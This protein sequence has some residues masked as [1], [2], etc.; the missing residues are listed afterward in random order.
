MGIFDR[1]KAQGRSGTPQV[2]DR[3]ASP[4][5]PPPA[6][7]RS[8]P[9][10]AGPGPVA[11][12]LE[13]WSWTTPLPAGVVG[14]AARAYPDRLWVTVLEPDTLE[15]LRTPTDEDE[16]RLGM[17][18]FPVAGTGYRLKD[19]TSP[20][21]APASAV[22]LVPE[23]KNRHDRRAIAVRSV[24]GKRLA[25]YVPR[26]SGDGRDVQGV[27]HQ[28][29]ATGPV[30]AAVLEAT[31]EQ[32]ARGQYVS[33]WV[34]AARR[35]VLVDR[36]WSGNPDYK[37][38]RLQAQRAAAARWPTDRAQLRREVER[39]SSPIDRHFALQQLAS[40]AYKLRDHHPEALEDAAAACREQIMLAEVAGPALR[41]EF[42]DKPG[43]YGY[44][45]LAIILEKQQRFEEALEVV[46]QAEQQG[47][48]GDWDKR[49]KRL[50]SKLDKRR[51]R[52]P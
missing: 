1:L 17:V 51:P 25:G 29:L 14:L 13:P 35:L 15:P 41:Q 39:H 40:E 43:H 24:D 47:W 52:Q 50:S 38:F 4:G 32:G 7:A 11:A 19:A 34:V 8:G 23:P 44:K 27:L 37:A 22:R 5:A 21:F 2:H 48:S 49:I 20:A 12:G 42:G 30:Q 3:P 31:V 18:R 36:P 16:A 9:R 45:Q 46:S 28:V 33:M 6:G 10:D 26:P